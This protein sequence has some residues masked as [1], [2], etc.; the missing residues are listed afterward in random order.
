MSVF[1]TF[2]ESFNFFNSVRYRTNEYFIDGRK[3]R[4][5]EKKVPTSRLHTFHSEG[6]V[7]K[8]IDLGENYHRSI[9]K[10]EAID[11]FHPNKINN[12]EFWKE[13]RKLFPLVA[14]CGVPSKNIDEVNKQTLQMSNDF[15]LLPFLM[16]KLLVTV[17]DQNVLEIGYGYGNLFL[18]IK[19]MCN[20]Y[21]IDY[22]KPYTLRKYKNLYEI[23]E[24]GIPENLMKVNFFDVVYCVNV[25][26]HCSQQDR[27][28]YFKQ[29]SE[30]LKPGGHFLFT[31]F[32]MTEE[33]KDK[34][35]WGVLDEKG[36]GYTHFFNQL[37]EC[38]WEY[39]L[40][41]VLSE[42]GFK[43]IKGRISQN[44]LSMIVQK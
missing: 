40:S 21:G 39:E 16:E 5:I 33:N 32:L 22:I 28:I 2:Q 29:A 13:C 24:S 6:L 17:E 23:N 4:F 43:V 37:T 42:I 41:Y 10:R 31:E 27:F 9:I 15:G 26:Q 18:K 14:V 8:D 7:E 30:V 11:R 34:S 25:L 1:S 38:D 36:R 19:D 35:F 44:A 12:K 20:Y 3:L